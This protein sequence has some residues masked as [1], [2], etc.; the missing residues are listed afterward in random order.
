MIYDTMYIG[1]SRG[2]IKVI[3]GYKKHF[4]I[5]LFLLKILMSKTLLCIMLP[6]ILTIKVIYVLQAY[7][8]L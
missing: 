4:P 2:T 3:N 8:G 5:V 6:L 1:M 7:T